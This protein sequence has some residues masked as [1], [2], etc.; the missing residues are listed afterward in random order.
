[1]FQLKA[2]G[3]KTKYIAGIISSFSTGALNIK[4]V[5]NKLEIFF[6]PPHTKEHLVTI[7][8]VNGKILKVE[9]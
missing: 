2:G 6:V 1:M 9:T 7:E 5:S 4:S 8:K 3:S